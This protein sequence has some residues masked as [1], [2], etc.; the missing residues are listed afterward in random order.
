VKSNRK[1]A[2]KKRRE[3]KPQ[4][5]REERGRGSHERTVADRKDSRGVAETRRG[6][7]K[8]AIFT[9]PRLRVKP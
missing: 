4:R 9:P 1:G 5:H 8:A 6:K 3:E 2:K 7:K